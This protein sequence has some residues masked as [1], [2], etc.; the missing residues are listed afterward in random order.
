MRRKYKLPAKKIY[1]G[2]P[3]TSA[4]VLSEAGPG[5][6]TDEKLAKETENLAIETENVAIGAENLTIEVTIERLNNCSL[7]VWPIVDS[8]NERQPWLYSPWQNHPELVS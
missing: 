3:G 6:V 2:Q 4:S 5:K 8:F 1:W 7:S